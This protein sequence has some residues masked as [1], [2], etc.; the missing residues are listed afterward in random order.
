MSLFGK[1]FYATPLS[2]RQ[3]MGLQSLGWEG[4]RWGGGA[5]HT[6]QVGGGARAPT[7]ARVKYRSK[8]SKINVRPKIQDTQNKSRSSEVTAAT[9]SKAMKSQCQ[10][11]KK[12]F[13]LPEKS[14]KMIGKTKMAAGRQRQPPAAKH[15]VRGADNPK[16]RKIPTKAHSYQDIKI[17]I[18]AKYMTS[19]G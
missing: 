18:N 4:R 9:S 3:T 19:R 12:K 2:P 11:R 14:S 5:R 10:K 8:T 17:H 6:S 1:L 16:W 15:V 7:K 13:C